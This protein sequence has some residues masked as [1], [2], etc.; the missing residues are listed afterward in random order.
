LHLVKKEEKVTVNGKDYFWCTGDHYSA[1]EKHNGM[2]ADH[3]SADHNMWH[4]TIDDCRATHT[5]GISL[6]DTPVPATS[7]IA[8]KLTLT[9]NFGMHFA[10]KLGS[11][12]KLLIAFGRRPRET[13][14]SKSWVE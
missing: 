8:Q 2:Y 12:L 3:K 5:S 1:G 14:R 6:N 9:T 7:A 4:K 10:L 11:L 13:S